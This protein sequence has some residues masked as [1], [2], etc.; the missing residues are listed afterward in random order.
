LEWKRVF[1]TAYG[2]QEVEEIRATVVE[3][4]PD[5]QTAGKIR[6]SQKPVPIFPGQLRLVAAGACIPAQSKARH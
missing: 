6:R 2:M 1:A 4:P 3:M 5:G